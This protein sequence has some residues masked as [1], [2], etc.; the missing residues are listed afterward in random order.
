MIINK[1]REINVHMRQDSGEKDILLR[2]IEE[3]KASITDSYRYREKWS[4]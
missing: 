3:Q 4:L 2:P 1:A